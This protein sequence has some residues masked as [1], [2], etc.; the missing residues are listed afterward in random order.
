MVNIDGTL[1]DSVYFSVIA[2]EWPDVSA[3]LLAKMHRK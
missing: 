2:P 3:R 1:R